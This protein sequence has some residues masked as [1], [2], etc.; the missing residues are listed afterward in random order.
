MQS[1][2]APLGLNTNINCTTD[3][4]N[5]TVTLLYHSQGVIPMKERPLQVNK[6]VLNKQVF[7]VLSI[8]VSDAGVYSCNATNQSGTT[9]TRQHNIMV[10][11]QSSELIIIR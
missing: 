7:T 6:I 8:V 9:I 10:Q 11:V 5:A 3:D 2:Q 1:I 4:P